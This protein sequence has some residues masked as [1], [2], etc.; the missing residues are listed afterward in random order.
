MR[1]INITG[2]KYDCARVSRLN[3]AECYGACQDTFR[4]LIKFD[5][6]FNWHA[7]SARRPP[8]FPVNLRT[9]IVRKVVPQVPPFR[10]ARRAAHRVAVS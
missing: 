6:K 7:E 8:T 3:E 1:K 5:R 4:E 2:G 9:C 10:S